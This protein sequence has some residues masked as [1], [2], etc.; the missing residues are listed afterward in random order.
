MKKNKE[1]TVLKKLKECLKVE[2]DLCNNALEKAKE[3]KQYQECIEYQ[4]ELTT[5]DWVL[6][7][8]ECLEELGET[9]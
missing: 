5:I 9:L 6:S 1:K 2:I 3:N 7:E 8:I 4:F